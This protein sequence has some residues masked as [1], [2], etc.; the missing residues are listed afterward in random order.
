MIIG[1]TILLL[2]VGLSGCNEQIIAEQKISVVESVLIPLSGTEPPSSESE[3]SCGTLYCRGEI[4]QEEPLSI[5]F[6]WRADV[7]FPGDVC[8]GDIYVPLF[9]VG[10]WEG[11]LPVPNPNNWG[12]AVWD[13]AKGEHHAWEYKITL[14]ENN[15]YLE[16]WGDD[17][18]TW[19][20]WLNDIAPE[21]Y[22]EIGWSNI[23]EG[24]MDVYAAFRS[25]NFDETSFTV[26]IATEPFTL[27]RDG[28]N[29]YFL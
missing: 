27:G 21:D 20:S 10:S 6:S 8:M 17:E 29:F 14:Y 22:Q 28:N 25:M 13:D 2:A 16:I 7:T 4:N 5:T 9:H 12:S 1:I 11:Y 24:T 19:E 18:K 15:T 23:E 3:E 26:D